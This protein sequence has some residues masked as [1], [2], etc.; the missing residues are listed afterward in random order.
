MSDYRPPID[1]IVFTLEEVAGLGEIAALDAFSGLDTEFVGSAL[2]EAGRFCAEVIGSI[3]DVSDT[4]G[5]VR[6][7]D[8]SVTTPA[9]FAEVYGKFVESGWPGAAFP[10]QW[11]GGGMPFT[12]GIAVQEMVTTADMAF[13]LCPMLT[14]GAIELLLEYGT[15]EQ[16]ATYLEKLITGEWTGTMVLTEP[17]AGSDVGALTTRA[18]AADDG[19]YR[20]T[21]QKIFI[22][23]GEHDM[24][25]N[26]IHLVLARTPDAPAGTR[27]ISCFIVP[28]YLVLPDGSIGARN[29]VSCVSIEHKLGIHGSPTCVLSFGDGDDGAV[30][31]LVGEE[32]QG[33]RY[34]FLMM[35]NARLQVGLEGLGVAERALQ[36]AAA[37]SQVRRQGR[38]I[39]APKTE[40]S[41]IA[42]HPDVR[43]TL[44]LMRSRVE[45]MRGVM[46]RNARMIDLRHHAATHAEREHADE[47]AAILTPISKAW[48]TDLG[49]ECASLGIQV[50]GGMGYVE[51]TG[52]A[53]LLRDA[54][55]APIYEGTNGI[56]AQDL[57]M[58]KLP[59]R[60]GDAV[61]EILADIRSTAAALAGVADL[62]DIG[63]SLDA[64]VDALSEAS[65]WL[66]DRLSDHPND[67]LAAATPYLEMFGIT[68]GG[69]A[70]GVSALAAHRRLADP[71]GKS[72]F[73]R[74]KISTARFY[75]A[76]EL[77][78]AAGLIG[79]VTAGADGLFEIAA[80]RLG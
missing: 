66:L 21:G 32:Q 38:A 76:H 59:I 68:L 55:I 1:D 45:A 50:H 5:S 8:G 39:G 2:E 46:Y 26:I 51:E 41:L 15:E 27:G 29:D 65:E 62:A 3:H 61:R 37:F 40:S 72:D 33:M 4:V 23:W 34:M 24:T 25:D 71:N 43:R 70:L 75:A 12:V 16:Q 19:T 63:A 78:R 58:R 69:W 7:A 56:Q 47:M 64:S 28:K 42:E 31:Y 22:T 20:I 36:Q 9:G 74:D 18:V 6:N 53:R 17:Q 67:A 48:G 54:R 11:G 44:M 35:N 10:E 14:F 49:V 77:P 13:S 52:A 60:G 80:E 30:G 73:Y 79:S 57:A